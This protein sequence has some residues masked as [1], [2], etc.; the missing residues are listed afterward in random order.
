MDE[1]NETLRQALAVAAANPN[2]ALHLLGTGLEKAR[3]SGDCRGVSI[4][5]RHAGII[6]SQSGNLPAALKHYAEALS[7]S[8]GDAYLHFAKGD[9]H[10]ELGQSREARSAFTRSLELATEQGDTDVVKMASEARARLGGEA[11]SN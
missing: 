8:P 6:S 7:A 10:R 1:V 3:K 4:F 9:V 2:E 5:A 11:D